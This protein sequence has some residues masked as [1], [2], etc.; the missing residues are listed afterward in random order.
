MTCSMPVPASQREYQSFKEQEMKGI[1]TEASDRNR[2]YITAQGGVF[3]GMRKDFLHNKYAHT[4]MTEGME[5]E[6]IAGPKSYAKEI[7]IVNWVYPS[8]HQA[9][10]EVVNW[11]NGMGTASL[12]CGC[13]VSLYADRFLTDP[14]YHSY[15]VQG[16][17]IVADLAVYTNQGG[18]RMKATNIEILIPEGAQFDERPVQDL[19]AGEGLG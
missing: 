16:A 3:V 12:S 11:G 14:A 13:H 18:T 4:C 8:M 6:F 17:K 9:E 19:Q 2:C 5:V 7:R 10:L 15:L 1:I